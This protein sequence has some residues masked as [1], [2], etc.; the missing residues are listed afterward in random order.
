VPEP[1]GGAHQDT[2]AAAEML[3]KSIVAA[4][5][6]LDKMSLSKLLEARYEKFRKVGVFSE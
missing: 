4:L 5:D 3:G 2:E 1:Q 6:E